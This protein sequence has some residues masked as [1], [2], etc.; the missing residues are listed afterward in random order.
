MIWKKLD[1]LLSKA[2]AKGFKVANKA[3]IYA[4][5]TILFIF[6]YNVVG[7]FRDYNAFFLEARVMTPL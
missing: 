4:I 5:N 6:A 3:H 1:A 2:E 7:V